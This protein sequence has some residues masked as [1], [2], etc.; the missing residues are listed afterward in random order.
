MHPGGQQPPILTDRRVELKSNFLRKGQGRGGSP[1]EY[2]LGVVDAQTG[3]RVSLNL[4]Q[5]SNDSP[6]KAAG[7]IV[8]IR[9]DN[10]TTVRIRTKDNSYVYGNQNLQGSIGSH[11][12]RDMAVESLLWQKRRATEEKLQQYKELKLRRHIDALERK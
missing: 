9:R 10:K 3:Q 12:E 8:P 1:T 2:D 6:R 5:S 11:E 7:A 4:S